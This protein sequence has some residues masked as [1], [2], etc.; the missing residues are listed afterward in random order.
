MKMR[1][2]I[3]HLV[4]LVIIAMLG[5]HIAWKMFDFYTPF[6]QV[7]YIF[8]SI[9]MPVFCY[10]LV[11]EFKRTESIRRLI[12]I[13]FCLWL[14]SIFP[15]NQYGG[16]SFFNRQNLLFDMILV[17]LMLTSLEA[18]KVNKIRKE[19]LCIVIGVFFFLSAS[20]GNCPV[21]PLIFG[22][23]FY[24]NDWNKR[25]G[26][27]IVFITIV[28]QCF[29]IGKALVQGWILKIEGAP[30]W[31]GSLYMLGIL[32]VVPLL[33]NYR[34]D[35][36]E[37]KRL[38]YTV[39]YVYA[40]HFLILSGL[41]NITDCSFY[42]FY[43]QLNVITIILV[44][45]FGC[46]AYSTKPSRAQLS[47]IVLMIFAFFY[48]IG[49]YIELTTMNLNVIYVAN[50]I[51]YCGLVGMFSAFTNFVENFY[52]AKF[53][54]I[55]Y[56]IEGAFALLVLYCI[57]TIESNTVFIKEIHL[58]D[59][60][61]HVAV[62]IVPGSFYYIFYIYIILLYIGIA[63]YCIYRVRK[64]NSSEKRR[65]LYI[66][67]GAFSPCCALF[68]RFLGLTGGYNIMTFGVLGF[69]LFFTVGLLR[70]D[71]FSKIQT[72]SE[73]DPLTGVSNRG[74]FKD[75]VELEL[76]MRKRGTLIMLD[77][78][79]FKFINDTLGH[80]EG[81]RVLITLAE[82]LKQTV[83]DSNYVARIGGDEFCIYLV[84][85]MRKTEI[86]QLIK[87]LVMVF[88]NNIRDLKPKRTASLSIGI[89]CY[90]GKYDI[91]FET[92]YE[93]ADKALY[94]AKKCG[95]SQYRFF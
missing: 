64:G 65:C 72:D 1:L 14:V 12:G 75:M 95:K 90:S 83:S 3:S 7:F 61:N 56:M 50:K 18:Y 82:T 62:D 76:S 81:D 42:N 46:I 10:L 67:A 73:K 33:Q 40:I 70:D 91:E 79:N 84:N 60:G 53:T 28:Y 21:L 94:L 88:Q 54:K 66:L 77:M 87:S 68:L 11:E 4:F 74:Y 30:K 39:F 37:H 63:S 71:Y 34:R 85:Q 55:I 49:F 36:G 13:I 52:H 20:K 80:G 57:F 35:G 6:A 27:Q 45:V 31:Y 8:G 41:F 22:L 19:N 69:I 5:E 38:K 32:L 48:M 86:E 51:E 93:N 9:V 44:V 16:K 43:I 92:L 25:T 24:K 2:G 78:D 26:K 23:L 58:I 47:N 29:M 59:R 89:A 15:Y 17:L